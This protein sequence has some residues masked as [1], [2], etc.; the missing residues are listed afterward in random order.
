MKRNS[1]FLG[2][3]LFVSALANLYLPAT[4]SAQAIAYTAAIEVRSGGSLI[5]YVQRDPNYWTPMITPDPSAAFVVSFVLPNGQSGTGIDLRTEPLD[6][7]AYFGPVVGRDST[8]PDIAPGSF[9]Y[10]YLG[11]INQTPPNSTPQNVG[12]WFGS[13]TGLAKASESAVWTIDIPTGT[14]A[15]QWVNTD[16][17]KPTTFVFVQSNHVYAGGDPAAFNSRF[18]APV[19]I[20]TLHLNI[21]SSAPLLSISSLTATPNVLWPPNQ[22]MTLV[23]L[24]AT[25]EGG[26]GSPSCT[27]TSVASSDPA[28]PDG[29]WEITGNLTV[30]LRAERLTDSETAGS[31][32]GRVY[33][34]TV[35]C[36]DGSSKASK[37][38]TVLVP[39]SRGR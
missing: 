3:S 17:S 36:T 10:L 1:V 2:V 20:V 12:S 35:E 6:G 24:K 27:I 31:T 4:A 39:H 28:G 29:D 5:G 9:N 38:T 23:T 25:T 19:T 30:L 7:F 8:S 22:K 33:S 15:P 18:P 14:L 32:A 21:L 16:S 37:T 11:H 34:I 26:S 13:M